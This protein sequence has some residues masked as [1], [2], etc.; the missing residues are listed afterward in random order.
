MYMLG[1][2]ATLLAR[3]SGLWTHVIDTLHRQDNMGDQLQVACQ[4]H[5]ETVTIVKH[6]DDFKGVPDGGCWLKCMARLGC[7]HK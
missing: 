7:G 4:N 1:N 6:P 5:P 3:D 2:A